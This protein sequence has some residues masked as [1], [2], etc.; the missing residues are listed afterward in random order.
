VEEGLTRSERKTRQH[1]AVRDEIK[2][3][4]WNRIS[5]GG[6]S[7][8]SLRGVA[9]FMGLTAPAL[10]RYFP[11]KNSLITAL[12]IDAFISLAESQNTILAELSGESWQEQLRGLGRAYRR[13]ALERPEVFLLIFG[14]P[15]PGYDTPFEETMPAAGESLGALITV[16]DSAWRG[17]ALKLPLDPPATASLEASLTGWSEAVHKA[18]PDA[19]YLAFIISTRV[20]GM[21]LVELGRQLPPFFADGNDL[22]ERELS[23]IIIQLQS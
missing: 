5:G 1:D 19:L 10:Y 13:W 3:A 2:R 16:I 18:H 17:G 15:V 11:N 7:A 12:I 8:L 21:M 4:A 23:R 9:S 6:A 14:N 20:Q 22:F